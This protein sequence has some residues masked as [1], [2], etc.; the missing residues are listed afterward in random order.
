MLSFLLDSPEYEFSDTFL[1]VE[2]GSDATVH[3]TVSSNPPIR[4]DTKHAITTDGHPA[5]RRFR[6]HH[7]R[8]VL[9]KLKLEDTGMYH[10]SSENEDHLSGEGTF[11]IRVV[12]SRSSEFTLASAYIFILFQ[13]AS[14]QRTLKV[15]IHCLNF[16]VRR[17]KEMGGGGVWE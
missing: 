3:F 13:E 5:T 11:E 12:K 17:E 6:A 15:L 16:K 9:T 1:E 2:E 4:Q 14:H 7:N 10:I 8:I